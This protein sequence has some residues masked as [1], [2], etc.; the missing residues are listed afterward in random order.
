MHKLSKSEL[1]ALAALI[2]FG[3]GMTEAADAADKTKDTTAK[4]TTESKNEDG[5]AKK[6]V[7]EV[8]KHSNDSKGKEM[9]C[10]AD[11]KGQEGK[12]GK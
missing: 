3:I 10:G 1:T 2:S 12:C 8:K 7:K 4:T 9:A 5:S 6:E 11:M